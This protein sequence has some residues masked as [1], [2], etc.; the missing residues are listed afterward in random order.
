LNSTADFALPVPPPL[1]PKSSSLLAQLE[2]LSRERPDRVLRLQGRLPCG[3]MF[4][5]LIYRG[6]SSSTTHATAYDPDQSALA[7]GSA[8]TSAT[9]LE[10]PLKPGAE[11]ELAGPAP[12]ETFLLS[13]GWD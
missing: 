2:A 10:A 5:L 12:V 13:Q 11:I 9:L 3:E 4:E 8:M 6:F 1:P 7:E